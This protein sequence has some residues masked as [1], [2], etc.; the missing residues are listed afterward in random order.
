MLNCA[1]LHNVIIDKGNLEEKKLF[2]I[3]NLDLDVGYLLF[4]YDNVSPL[5]IIFY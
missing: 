1:E 4:P 3:Q 5:K 2:V